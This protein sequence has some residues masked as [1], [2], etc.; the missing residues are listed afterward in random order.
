MFDETVTGRDKAHCADCGKIPAFVPRVH[1][2]NIHTREMDIHYLQLPH[3]CDTCAHGR[4]LSRH[5]I[6]VQKHEHDNLTSA[7]QRFL[8][9]V[10]DFIKAVQE[11]QIADLTDQGMSEEDAK[12]LLGVE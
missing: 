10:P 6:L 11:R 4:G 12:S 7:A 1:V 3:L 8:D 9:G 5:G 2:A